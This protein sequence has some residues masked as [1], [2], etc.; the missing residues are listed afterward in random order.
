MKKNVSHFSPRGLSIGI[1]TNINHQHMIACKKK[2]TKLFSERYT[3]STRVVFQ[4][5]RTHIYIIQYNKPMKIVFHLEHKLEVKKDGVSY[6]TQFILH[7]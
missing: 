6:I 1:H 3:H 4:H 2:D 7:S 5:K